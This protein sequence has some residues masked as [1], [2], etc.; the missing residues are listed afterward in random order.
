MLARQAGPSR[1]EQPEQDGTLALQVERLPVQ[2][3]EP[4]PRA[5]RLVPAARALALTPRRLP[6]SRRGQ[7]NRPVTQDQSSRETWR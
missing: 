6:Q 3:G 2:P 4:P 1:Q 7:R 5:P